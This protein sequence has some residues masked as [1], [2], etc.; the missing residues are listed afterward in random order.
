MDCEQRQA[1]LEGLGRVE[2]SGEEIIAFETKVAMAKAMVRKAIADRIPF[3]GVTA[4]AA[5]DPRTCVTYWSVPLQS[6]G[7]LC[8]PL[9]VAR[10]VAAGQH[11]L[12]ELGDEEAPDET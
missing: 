3:A 5:F 9:S 2:L 11:A 8:A 12:A 4:D 10:L 6:P 1:R 7:Q